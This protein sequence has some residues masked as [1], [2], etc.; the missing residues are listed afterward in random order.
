MSTDNDQKPVRSENDEIPHVRQS[1]KRRI[2]RSDSGFARLLKR[3]YR[4]VLGVRIP[5]PKIVFLPLLKLFLGF[6][7]VFYFLKRVL[8]CE[9]M[10]KAYCESVGKRF[11]TSTFLHWVQGDGRIVIGDDVLLNGKCS[12]MFAYRYVENPVLLIGDGVDISHQCSFVIGRR[13][14]IG[15]RT[16]IGGGVSIRDSNGHPTGYEERKKGAALDAAE[17]LPVIIEEDCWIGAG[18]S[19]GPGVRIGKGSVVSAQSVVMSS[20]PPFS[21]FAG[22]P[23]RRIGTTKSE[24]VG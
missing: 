23:A 17:V 11:R 14:E 10:F 6:R 7:A 13:V 18:T 24:G 22:N 19:I 15:S 3:L 2:A 8:F 1:L 21:V 9:P 16:M 5:A 4:M 12:I 20:V